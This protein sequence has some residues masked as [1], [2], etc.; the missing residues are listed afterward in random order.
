MKLFTTYKFL[1]VLV[2]FLLMPIAVVYAQPAFSLLPACD[3]LPGQANSCGFQHLMQLAINIYNYLLYFASFIAL[4][5]LIWAGVRMLWFSYFEHSEQE[6]GEAKLTFT[7]AIAGLVIIIAAFLIV[8]TLVFFLTGKD[9][10]TVI[11]KGIL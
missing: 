11:D 3:P 8:N 5:M 1:L 9:L 6:L 2:A 4:L 7:R 10:N